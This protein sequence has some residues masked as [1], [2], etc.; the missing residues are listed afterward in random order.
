MLNLNKNNSTFIDSLCS[1]KIEQ[2]L[3]SNSLS[4]PLEI[5]IVFYNNFNTNKTFYGFLLAQQEKTKKITKKK[6]IV[7][8]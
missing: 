8:S 3:Y 2:I 4:I 5:G 7:S 6:D 1:E